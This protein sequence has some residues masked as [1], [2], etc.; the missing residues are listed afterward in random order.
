MPGMGRWEISTRNGGKP[1]MGGWFY[2]EGMGNSLYILGR[3]VLTPLFYRDP[4][5]Y[6]QPPLFKFCPHLTPI[7]L[8]CHFLLLND[9]MD[10]H[11]LRLGT[12][13]PEGPWCEV[14][15]GL[16]H[17]VVFNWYSDVTS[18]TSTQT[19]TAHSG[20]SKLTHQYKYIFIPPPVTCSPQLP[21]LH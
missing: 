4:P 3:G 2:N 7:P 5:L 21:L 6:C 1:V 16:T 17:N 10:R 18:H 9:N 13:V 14:C 15:R 12:L 8:P 20:A 11:M 19:H